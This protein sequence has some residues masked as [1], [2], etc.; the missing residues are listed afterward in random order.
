MRITIFG[1]IIMIFV[2]FAVLFLYKMG[3]LGTFWEFVKATIRGF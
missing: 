3:L 2:I 1:M